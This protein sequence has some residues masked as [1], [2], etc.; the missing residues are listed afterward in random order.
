MTIKKT[1]KSLFLISDFWQRW[2][3]NPAKKENH[4]SQNDNDDYDDNKN[5]A[6]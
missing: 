5:G 3:S 4:F 6:E 2:Q 1:H